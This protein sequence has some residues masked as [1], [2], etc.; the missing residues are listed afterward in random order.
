MLNVATIALTSLL[1]NDFARYTK[2]DISSIILD[3]HIISYPSKA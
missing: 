2:D 3:T 1:V